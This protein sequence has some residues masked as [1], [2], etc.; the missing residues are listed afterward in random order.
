ML[1]E[2][3]EQPIK[4]DEEYR[5]YDKPSTSAGGFAFHYHLTCQLTE[6]PRRPAPAPATSTRG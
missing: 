4:P 6:S 2:R 5:S 1:C 3:C